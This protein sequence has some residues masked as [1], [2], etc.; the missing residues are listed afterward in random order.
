MSY[1][2]V[3]MTRMARGQIM[4]RAIS[5]GSNNP[6]TSNNTNTEKKLKVFTE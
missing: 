5:V 4:Y 6:A 3:L 2:I 1:R